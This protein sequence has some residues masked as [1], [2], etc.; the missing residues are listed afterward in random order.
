MMPSINKQSQSLDKIAGVQDLSDE[1]AVTCS[2]G[3]ITLWTG[4]N[5]TGTSRVYTGDVNDLGAFRNIFSSFEVESGT[6]YELF[7]GKNKTGNGVV[8]G[9]FFG[10]GGNFGFGFD[11]NV[12]SIDR[13]D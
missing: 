7:T 4:A 2:G 8:L 10:Q 3:Q 11:N 1:K 6:L 9:G 12:E 5:R 13:L